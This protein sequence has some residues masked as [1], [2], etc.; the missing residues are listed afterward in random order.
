MSDEAS[1]IAENRRRYEALKRAGQ[2]HAPRALPG[3]SPRG[4]VPLDA[5][6]ILHRETL[7]GGW[8]WTTALKA[9]EA[10]RLGLDHG[11]SSVALVAWSAADPSE[12]L[13]TAD[14]VKVQW[15]ASLGKGRVLFSDMGRVMLSMIEDSCGAHDAL[16]GGSN[17][18]A[19][20]DRYPG[21]PHRNTRDNL[22]LAALKRGLERR[23]I[24]ACLSFF[25]PVVVGPE[26]RFA[27]NDAGRVTGDFVDL[28]AEMDLIVALSNCPHPLDPAPDYA[29]SP[30][31]VTRFRAPPPAAD[32]LCRTATIE[33]V[34]GFENTA[35]AGL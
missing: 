8:Y 22:V 21:G 11:P 20:A 27:W 35:F 6:A 4:G 29:P 16:V 25:A 33:A 13:N 17:A 19:N 28:R 31:A 18:S 15:T 3:P 14:T 5:G 9:G 7:P 24:P 10:L 32:D 26:G 1:V 12:R 23:D 30:V 34:R 2:G